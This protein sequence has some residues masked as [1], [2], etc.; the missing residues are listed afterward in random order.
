[1][2]FTN[3]LPLAIT[4]IL[5]VTNATPLRR[6]QVNLDCGDTS[7][8]AI[9]SGTGIWFEAKTGDSCPP[10]TPPAAIALPTVTQRNNPA[11]CYYP[12]SLDF[13]AM[14]QAELMATMSSVATKIY[15]AQP[16]GAVICGAIKTANLPVITPATPGV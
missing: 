3:L 14:G 1:M 12:T 6:R 11:S 4:T 15:N 13:C 16:S 10:I 2:L 7:S 5:S 8:C 9:Y